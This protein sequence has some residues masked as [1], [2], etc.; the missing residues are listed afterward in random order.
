M[1]S[2]GQRKTTSD[3]HKGRQIV[4]QTTLIESQLKP[5]SAVR[6]LPPGEGESTEGGRGFEGREW[7]SSVPASFGGGCLLGAII[8][9]FQF[10]AGVITYS[11]YYFKEQLWWTHKYS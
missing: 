9:C 6:P 4:S 10:P 1:P 11:S 3:V 7:V 2:E 5:T 8:Y